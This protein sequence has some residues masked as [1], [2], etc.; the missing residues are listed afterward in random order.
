MNNQSFKARA[1]PDNR[2][3][4]DVVLRQL[5][6]SL[7]TAQQRLLIGNAVSTQQQYSLRIC[8]SKDAIRR[9]LDESSSKHGTATPCVLFGDLSSA[10]QSPAA[11]LVHGA[12]PPDG[13]RMNILYIYLPTQKE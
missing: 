8:G 12:T 6:G 9:E 1:E 4:L 11:I 2:K 3:K 7:L 5:T 10:R 13:R